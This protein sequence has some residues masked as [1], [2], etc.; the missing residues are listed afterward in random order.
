MMPTLADPAMFIPCALSFLLGT[1]AW[2]ALSTL[3]AWHERH[4]PIVPD[5]RDPCGRGCTAGKRRAES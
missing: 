4:R 2:P 5:Y 1:L 3:I